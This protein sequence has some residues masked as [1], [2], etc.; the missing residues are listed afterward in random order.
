MSAVVGSVARASQSTLTPTRGPGY[1]PIAAGHVYRT[2]QNMQLMG[3]RPLDAVDID[4]S[5]RNRDYTDLAADY[6]GRALTRPSE[7][8]T[9]ALFNGKNSH[10][11]TVVAPIFL[12]DEYNFQI[13]GGEAL[14]IPFDRVGPGGLARITGYTTRT[15]FASLDMF[16]RSIR[17]EMS[18][19]VDKNY[20]APAYDQACESLRTQ[21]EMTLCLMVATA[22]VDVPY[23]ERMNR[24]SNPMRP[25]SHAREMLLNESENFLLGNFDPMLLVQQIVGRRNERNQINMAVFAGGSITTLI[26]NS[27]ES[28]PMP[29]FQVV[30][31]RNK[32]RTLLASVDGPQALRSVPIGNGNVLNITESHEFLIS[33]DDAAEEAMQPL[34]S[35]ITLGEMAIMKRFRPGFPYPT[36]PGALDIGLANHDENSLTVERITTDVLMRNCIH[37]YDRD[38]ALKENGN[39]DWVQAL[40]AHYN[41]PARQQDVLAYLMSTTS[42][43]EVPRE[44]RQRDVALTAMVGFRHHYAFV[45][46]KGGVA[47]VRGAGGVITS[48]AEPASIKLAARV[49]DLPPRALSVKHVID[50]ATML[51]GLVGITDDDLAAAT[52]DDAAAGQPAPNLAGPPTKTLEKLYAFL[53]RALPTSLNNEPFV[54]ESMRVYARFLQ[55]DAALVDPLTTFK[56]KDGTTHAHFTHVA[57]DIDDNAPLDFVL[58]ADSGMAPR[59][60]EDVVTYTARFKQ[61]APA[62]VFAQSPSGWRVLYSHLDD[63][64]LDNAAALTFHAYRLGVDDAAA[65][66]LQTLT[67]ELGARSRR[68]HNKEVLA[69]ALR[70]MGEGGNRSLAS[71]VSERAFLTTNT[72]RRLNSTAANTTVFATGMR[73][74]VTGVLTH[75]GAA[76]P[77]ANPF[78]FPNEDNFTGPTWDIFGNAIP[79][80]SS[81]VAKIMYASILRSSF[82]LETVEALA[83]VGAILMRV[84]VMKPGI[85]LIAEHVALLKA[86]GVTLSMAL[87]HVLVLAGVDAAEGYFSMHAQFHAG[88]VCMEPRK[89]DLMQYTNTRQFLGGR[90]NRPILSASD[91]FDN[92]NHRPSALHVAVPVN[93]TNYAFPVSMNNQPAYSAPNT[94][95]I[96]PFQKGSWRDALAAFVNDLDEGLDQYIQFRDNSSLFETSRFAGSLHRACTW[97]TSDEHTEMKPVTGTGPLRHVA[98]NVPEAA[99]VF[100]GVGLFPTNYENVH[101]F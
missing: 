18:K 23:L 101:V 87:G 67:T 58:D 71:I 51:A 84:N 92:T 3:R 91:L 25:F 38:G 85:S 9:A 52:P 47:A 15:R 1:S 40:V 61:T 20:G 7:E 72:E 42:N 53:Q 82:S 70:N 11:L 62:D 90:N 14:Q 80:N 88:P 81:N 93:E 95:G 59:A 39:A 41:E 44:Y 34:R 64:A 37:W 96:S 45:G 83:R 4:A 75:G 36:L 30:Y 26:S 17:I 8:L 89:M 2:L 46:V 49:G 31:D 77:A 100:N 97:Y 78:A 60:D 48:P 5:L 16:K 57:M 32:E 12:T 33:I 28:R 29:A 98:M 99:R 22:L 69:S 73:A 94:D 24:L 86:D 43:D 35:P 63:D 79:Q 56:R 54:A 68:P 76:R 13:N 10:L 74:S 55:K 65:A 19:L 27:N 50:T 6:D 21:A 66:S